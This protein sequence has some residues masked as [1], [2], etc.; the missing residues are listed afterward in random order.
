M[1]VVAI[2]TTIL[3]VAATVY[4]TLRLAPLLATILGTAGMDVLTRLMGLILA[5]IALEF[6]AAGLSALFPGLM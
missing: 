2:A 1:H 3:I 5:A 6:I 4:A